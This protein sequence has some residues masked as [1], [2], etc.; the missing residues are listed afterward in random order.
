MYAPWR[1][2]GRIR[3]GQSVPVAKFGT[4]HALGLGAEIKVKASQSASIK[5]PT[6]SRGALSPSLHRTT[7][8]S[9]PHQHFALF[10]VLLAQFP[11]RNRH[12]STAFSEPF[13][14]QVRMQ[15]PEDELG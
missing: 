6:P 8:T 4:R 13:A 12:I 9:G 3:E 5:L 2:A 11:Q 14:T 1:Y 10:V 15:I 7:T